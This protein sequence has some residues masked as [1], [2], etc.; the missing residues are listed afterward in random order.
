MEKIITLKGSYYEI[1]KGWGAGFKGKM[2]KV[3]QT[4][5]GIIANFYGV[6][7]DT[8]IASGKKYLPIAMRVRKEFPWYCPSLQ[9]LR[10]N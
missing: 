5:L 3:V 10:Y 4:E 1:G 6:P 9:Q 8:I 2:E 7:V